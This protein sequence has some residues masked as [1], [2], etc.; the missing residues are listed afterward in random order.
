MQE[1]KKKVMRK[2]GEHKSLSSK[3]HFFLLLRELK[4]CIAR[5]LYEQNLLISV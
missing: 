2:K 3:F 4:K 5:I 1:E